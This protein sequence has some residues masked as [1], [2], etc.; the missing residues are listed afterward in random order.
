MGRQLCKPTVIIKNQGHMMLSKRYSK[1]PVTSPREK[2]IQELP[3]KEFKIII[4]K[5][6]RQ[7]QENKDKQFNGTRKTVQEQNEKFNKVIDNITNK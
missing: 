4:L 5:I 7:L 2:L 3:S 6:L 1:P